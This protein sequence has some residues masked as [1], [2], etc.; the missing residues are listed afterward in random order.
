MA[1]KQECVPLLSSGRDNCQAATMP[2]PKYTT[3]AYILHESATCIRK[4]QC[5][6][7]SLTS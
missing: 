2:D 7:D 6:Q 5:L 1:V 3:R 4:E